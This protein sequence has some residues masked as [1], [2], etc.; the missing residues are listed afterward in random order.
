[1]SIA[2][3]LHDPNFFRPFEA[4]ERAWA[5]EPLDG[6]EADCDNGNLPYYTFIE[7]QFDSFAPLRT[8]TTD[9]SMHPPA[10]VRD[11]ERLHRARLQRESAA[12][13]SCGRRPCWW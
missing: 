7:P 8:V 9:N 12:T 6:F 13:P 4:N 2:E 1:M 3:R 5:D 10:D 11:G